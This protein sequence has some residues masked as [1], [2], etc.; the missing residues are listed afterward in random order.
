M[1][2]WKAYLLSHLVVFGAGVYVGK[3]IDADELD[4]YR[5][6]HDE[7]SSKWRR[8]FWITGALIG[9]TTLVSWYISVLRYRHRQSLEM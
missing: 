9:G 7:S 2:T 4:G 5:R 8:R 1:K 3:C 6:I